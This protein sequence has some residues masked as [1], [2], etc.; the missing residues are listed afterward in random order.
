MEASRLHVHPA[1][2]CLRGG[3]LPITVRAQAGIGKQPLGRLQRSS[4]LRKRA[5]ASH[6]LFS[7]IQSFHEPHSSKG[8]EQQSPLLFFNLF[9]YLAALGLGCDVWDLVP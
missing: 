3:E 5:K 1:M 9:I 2:A 6:P 7:Q 4:G 8:A